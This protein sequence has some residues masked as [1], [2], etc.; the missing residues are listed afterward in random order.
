MYWVCDKGKST[1][2]STSPEMTE[3]NTFLW[4][5]SGRW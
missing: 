3:V 5:A 1:Y 2:Y 4:I